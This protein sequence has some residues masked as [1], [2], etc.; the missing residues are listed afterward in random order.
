M[1]LGCIAP[2]AV[3]VLL[4]TGW[5]IFATLSGVARAAGT[6]SG[7]PVDAPITIARDERGVP[8]IRASTLHDALFAEG[9]A[10]GSDRLFQLDLTRRYALGTLS[11]MVG[12]SA[13]PVDEEE[14]IVDVRGIVDRVYARMSPAEHGLLQAFADGVNAAATHE[15]APPEYHALFFSFAPWRPQD[16]LAVGYATVLELSDGGYDVLARD[17][18]SRA[19]GPSVAANAWYSLTDPV[20]DAPTVGDA[21][22]TLPP[23]PP[24]A[25]RAAA[26]R[27]PAFAARG[28]ALGSNA[29]ATG[30][31]R[32]ATGRALLAN[33]PHLRR[34][35]PGIWYLVELEAPGLHVAGA[36]LAGVPG[37]I[38]GHNDRLAWGTT[39]SYTVAARVFAETFTSTDGIAYRAGNRTLQARVRDE[40]FHV[41]LASDEHHR[42]L[43]TRHGFVIEGSGV[44]RHAVQWEPAED[45]RSPI[46]AFWGLD[47][48]GS[49]ADGLR[50]LASY[51][52]PTQNFVLAD[53]S[54]RVA[55]AMAGDV[56]DDPTWGLLASDGARTPPAPLHAIPA[57][58]LPHVAASR[59][60]FIATANNLPY[61][62]G[63][64]YRLAATFPD[65]PYRAAEG[66]RDL[67]HSA[68]WSVAAF[69]AEQA[70]T[71]SVA[72]AELARRTLAALHQT[73]ADRD[74]DLGPAIAALASFDGRFDPDSRGATVVQ[75]VRESAENELVSLHFGPVAAR[76]YFE[77]GPV[78]VTLM[79]AL[80]EH[81]RGWFPNNDPASFL[82]DAVRAAVQHYGKD[83][84]ATPYGQAYAVVALH[85]LNG[86]GFSFW[87]GPT[88]TGRGG[89]FSP[90]VQG[91]TL[92]QSF[93]AVWD[94][95]NWDAGG[96]DIP[97]GESGEP[98]S[99]HYHDLVAAWEQ[100]ALTPLAF[101]DAAIARATV[102]TLE[103]R[104]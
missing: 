6:V 35:E 21:P 23:L 29:W 104:P 56:V 100:N 10:L 60:A 87:N 8:H 91:P 67:A 14:R 12:S 2:F 88:L 54:G 16:A 7:L 5:I 98:G 62:R 89:S 72:E 79:R 49:I 17:I 22:L 86:F 26:A 36:T 20:W 81:P 101:S 92:S 99:K 45:P 41:R 44:V 33:D 32:S 11:E 93:R 97:L 94:V 13:L 63:Y 24:L 4:Y 75:R 18:V 39:N 27:I 71:T 52:G 34:T 38:L 19:A 3:V 73:G 80:R 70:D 96:I 47:Q 102:S 61:G 103:L 76:S 68:P 78:F 90:A 74:P 15:P 69:H 1:V 43:T 42:Y 53:V 64:P 51:P 57:A 28:G 59:T 25:S 37:V 84:I 66:R 77:T 30:A 95:G 31:A 50:A 9:Y 55:Y 85:P 65:G 58:A 40:T 82:A 46:A 83:A 48:A